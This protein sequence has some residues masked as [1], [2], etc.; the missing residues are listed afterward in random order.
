[1][2]HPGYS[3]FAFIFDLFHFDKNVMKGL[4]LVMLLIVGIIAPA[5]TRAQ[6][7]FSGWLA[8][9]NTYK[10]NKKVSIHNDIQLRSSDE[11]THVQTLLLRAGLNIHVNKQF[12]LT[13]GY[14]FIDNRRVIDVVAGHAVEH[15]TWEQ[16]LFS[17]K[18][19]PVTTTHR[20]RLEQRFIPKTFVS[21]NEIETDGHAYANRVRYFIRNMVPFQKQQ[22]FTKGMF[23]AVQDEVFLNV[24]N[25]ANVNGKTFDQNRFY[26]AVGYRLNPKFDLEA[27]YLNQYVKG[28]GQ[29][30]TNNHVL[31]VATYIRL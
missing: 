2:F 23:A 27:G 21:N 15:R 13:G 6:T 24:G 29:A 19:K 1:L 14:A 3:P 16:V 26:A 7:Q 17:H 5:G 22:S 31:Q 28:R 9:F 11:W 18:I 4:S 25:K 30:F 8:T 20:L 10:L 12:T